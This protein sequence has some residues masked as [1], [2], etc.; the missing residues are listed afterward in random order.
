MNLSISM[1]LPAR[2]RP[3]AGLLAAVLSGLLGL[4]S[5]FPAAAAPDDEPR[6][7]RGG[8]GERQDDA[9]RPPPPKM[10]RP[11]TPPPAPALRA[12]PAPDAHGDN[13]RGGDR[14]RDGP[15]RGGPGR[16]GADRSGPDGHEGR[17]GRDARDGR[18]GRGR[19]VRP[20]VVIVRP[21]DRGRHDDHRRPPPLR[22]GRWWDGAHGHNHQYP[23]PGRVVVLPP[24]PPAPLWWGGVSYRF[25]DGIWATS[26]P[27]G[28]VT[29]R[30]PFG[31]VVRDLPL[32]RTTLVIGGLTYFYANDVYYRPR[33]DD[34][35]EVVQPPLAQADATPSDRTFVYPRQG[36][37]AEQQASDEYEC[38]RW[39]VTQSGFDPSGVATGQ[40]VTVSTTSRGD[41][42]RA[43]VAC[44]EG[45]GYTVR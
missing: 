8:R 35:Y 15:G 45:R 33:G 7:L 37:S 2:A 25:W 42:Q 4:A 39:A 10:A 30:P 18:D 9:P 28:W 26:G 12:G 40:D 6:A 5:A 11:E 27:R 41:Y 32:F 43:R 38:H 31:I 20:P 17:D 24:R 13:R 14:G 34:G 22:D 16:D 19:D 44:L 36:Q 3:R 23:A 1:S 29:V 21:D